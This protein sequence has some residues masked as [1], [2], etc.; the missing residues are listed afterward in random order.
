MLST[1]I[2][3]WNRR[4]LLEQCVE[5]Y[6]ETVGNYF[7]L[8]IVDNAST[9]GSIE[10][11]RNLEANGSAKLIYLN[12]N[13]GGEAFNR[14]VPLSRGDLIHLSENDQI[15]LPGWYD[16]VVSS[17]DSFGDLG[18]L[19]LFS[20]TPTDD[21]VWESKASN[22]RFSNGKILYEAHGNVGTSSIVK[23]E[24]FRDIGIRVGNIEEGLFK[25]PNGDKLSADIKTA[26]FWCA[27]SDRYYVR[28]VGHE[29]AEFDAHENYYIQN[30]A[31][32]PGVG[33][34]GWKAR[35]AYQSKLPR[36][37]RRSLA[38]P[39]SS[40]V[41]EK[42]QHAVNGTPARMWSMYDG[43]TAEVE[44]LDLLMVLARLIKPTH[45]LETGTW[46]GLSSCAIARGLVAN[47]FGH[48]T[49]LEVNAEAHSM[50]LKN[51]A[52]YEFTSVVDAWLMS[53]MEYVPEHIFD[54]AV[55]DSEM[56]LRVHEFR[57]FKPSLREGA[58]VIFH[59]TAPHHSI[60]IDG[61]RSLIDEG[62]VVGVDLP[63]P[64]GVFVGR[65][66][67]SVQSSR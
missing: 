25:F 47:G 19:S 34:A 22:L 11:L 24:L 30:Y 15:F 57:R 4:Y 10:Y 51:L 8:I 1:I 55:F 60:V 2:L 31:S 64:R 13:M 49:T 7:E 3:N 42:T 17:F 23:A 36:T 43:F 33:V 50:A 58:L 66:S 61:V 41:P 6:L 27:W 44:V 65:V 16:H 26:G 59:D 28:N 46:L 32:K 37:F 35:I 39:D 45:V 14:A 38:F 20:D 54:M 63:T 53:S 5:S 62:A 12:E 48:L 29:R 18:Q 56:G 67:T 52:H 40:P 9:D 21:E